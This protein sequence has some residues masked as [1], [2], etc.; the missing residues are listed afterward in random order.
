MGKPTA[1]KWH[2]GFDERG[3]GPKACSPYSTR[4]HIMNFIKENSDPIFDIMGIELLELFSV[5]G[6]LLL[7]TLSKMPN[8]NTSL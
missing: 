1:M 3:E 4:K 2:G 6:V 5:I 7:N 8:F